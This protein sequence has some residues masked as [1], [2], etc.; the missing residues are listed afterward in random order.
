[1]TIDIET[2][3]RVANLARI[4]VTQNELSPLSKELSNILEFMKQL[5][6]VDVKDVAPLTSV[7]PTELNL[8][9][10]N[11]DD[12]EKVKDILLNAPQHS[13]GF[14]AVPKVIE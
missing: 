12:G 2:V 1:M 5:N 11:V 8:R 10:D 14:F 7:T 9:I 3:Q 4:N 13:Q 6:A